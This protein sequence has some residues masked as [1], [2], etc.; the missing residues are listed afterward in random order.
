MKLKWNFQGEG[1]GV[2]QKTPV[3]WGGGEGM[4]YFLQPDNLL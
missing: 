2:N 1:G 3:H 4:G